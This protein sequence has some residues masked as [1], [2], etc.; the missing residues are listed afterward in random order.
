MKRLNKTT[1]RNTMN[2][3]TQSNVIRAMAKSL[4]S[5]GV[6]KTLARETIS[7]YTIHDLPLDERKQYIEILRN[8]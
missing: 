8:A 4:L 3:E 1:L 2:D 5:F 7:G 6:R